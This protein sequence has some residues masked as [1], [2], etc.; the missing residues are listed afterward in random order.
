MGG[1]SNNLS[2][3]GGLQ[4]YYTPRLTDLLN[5][6]WGPRDP[7]A[8]DT[9][10]VPEVKEELESTAVINTFLVG[11]DPEFV[12][13]ENG[14]LVRMNNYFPQRGEIGFD[15][16]GAVGEFR[17][18]PAKGTWTLI[19]RIKEKVGELW[20]I[21]GIVRAGAIVKTKGRESGY[22]TL[23]GHVHLDICPYDGVLGGSGVDPNTGRIVGYAEFMDRY[24]N[25]DAT[26]ENPLSSASYEHRNVILGKPRETNSP[27][28]AHKDRVGALDT[29]TQLLEYLDILPRGECEERRK[30]GEY[31]KYGDVRIQE[32]KRTEYRT[33]ASWLFDPAVAFLCLTGAKIAAA[34]PKV[35]T[36]ALKGASAFTRLTDWLIPFASKDLD[37]GRLCERFL[38]LGHKGLIVDPSG[39]FRERWVVA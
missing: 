27:S 21:P 39:D 19:K 12:G 28:P 5:R 29:L 3:L 9:R 25:Y 34:E 17:P 11:C 18:R 37:V 31:G 22:V 10:G 35:C 4:Q 7:A 36:E 20:Q 30:T 8:T 32:K 24:R 2:Q 26:W 38:P 23:G 15:H 6:E 33:M 16:G 1:F 13:I 14:E